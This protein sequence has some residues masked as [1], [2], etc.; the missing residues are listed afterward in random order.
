MTFPEIGVPV[1]KAPKP[2]SVRDLFVGQ[3]VVRYLISNNL[4]TIL[5]IWHEKEDR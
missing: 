1:S 5:R 2:N 4:I 3:Y